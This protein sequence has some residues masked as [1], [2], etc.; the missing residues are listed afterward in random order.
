LL[1]R[2]DNINRLGGNASDTMGL[3]TRLDAGDVEGALGDAMTVTS[4]AREFGFL[5]KLQR[6]I[7]DGNMVTIDPMT[8]EVS[9][10]SLGLP[11]V[12]TDEQKLKEGELAA[13]IA[14]LNLESDAIRQKLGE[15]NAN[16]GEIRKEVR[17]N[18]GKTFR[19]LEGMVGAVESSFD[20]FDS[21]TKQI[22]GGN[23]SSVVPAIV[24]LVKLGDP[25][26]VVSQTEV[27]S[28][29]NPQD[30]MGSL[31]S[32]LAK[33][34]AGTDVINSVMTKLDVTNPENISVS[35]LRAV[36]ES[37]LKSSVR[38]IANTYDG[39]YQLANEN[40]TPEGFK[41]V[42]IKNLPD[43]LSAIN[44]L[45]FGAQQGGDKDARKAELLNALS[46]QGAR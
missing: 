20:K 42:F 40:L 44:S 1:N 28:S 13:K 45:T 24:A 30:P 18:T 16:M 38:S 2:V 21:L 5:P 27:L 12:K 22:E 32:A 10:K 8:G 46:G 26:S 34:G 9:T 37:M 17:A 6:Q 31:A 15:P 4:K 43:R 23:R 19:T 7:V 3:L 39:A 11:T 41:S 14:K 36:G 33:G 35:D 25:S 29:L